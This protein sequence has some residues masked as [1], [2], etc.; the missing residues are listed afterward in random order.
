MRP[1]PPR[2]A[3]CR[4]MVKRL[5]AKRF[6]R[7]RARSF[8]Y[9]LGPLILMSALACARGGDN[10]AGD[11]IAASALRASF[12][13]ESLPPYAAP[14]EVSTAEEVLDHT[15]GL[16]GYVEYAL[17][18]N[19][20]LRAEFERWQAELQKIPQVRAL[21][22]PRLTW[23]LFIEEIQTRTGPQENKLSLSQSFP[24][25][26]T[27]GLR[28]RIQARLADGV[29]W[30]LEAKKLALI[31]EVKRTYSEYAYLVRAIEITE[32][33]LHLLLQLE[34]VVQTKL[35]AGAGQG[36]LL[37]LQVEIGRI[38]DELN[39]L[40]A[41]RP[42]LS[43]RLAAAL[44]YPHGNVF[45][46]P[47]ETESEFA[48]ISEPPLSELVRR[49]N[50]SIQASLMET[51]T[52]RLRSQLAR[53]SGRPQ[54]TVGVDYFDTGSAL[55]PAT[56]GSG[57]DPYSVSVGVTLPI[58]FRKYDAERN[59]ARYR[60]RAAEAGARQLINSKQAELAGLLFRIDDAR[61]QTQLY[62]DT[63]IPR[64]RQTMEISRITYET[65]RMTLLEVIDSE[66]EV[67]DL[68]KLYW[69]SIADRRQRLADLE[70]LCG[71]EL[72]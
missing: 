58:W 48:E 24:W 28:G 65:G 59:E 18:H 27:L 21:P 53:L 1:H 5:R 15:R 10:I 38:E 23:T 44:N 40:I 25:F 8:S 33:T 52:A 68:E 63:L 43:A 14:P 72:Q 29:R 71:G 62:R 9:A 50:P 11:S 3:R 47:E 13:T 66:R 12:S 20:G 6:A 69:R 64:A 2:P 60:E 4:R 32:A 37:K 19:A 39:S 45:P 22:E 54:F 56:S 67:F 35:R 61:R 41:R 42:A 26:G 31:A 34:P 55:M 46:W 57:D 49:K 36:D 16:D 7:S 51:E 17:A 70:A 30:D